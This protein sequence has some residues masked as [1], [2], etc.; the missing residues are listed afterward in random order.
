MLEEVAGP[1]VAVRDLVEGA[2]GC[3]LTFD[4]GDRSIIDW[5]Y[6]LIDEGQDWPGDERDLLYSIFGAERV[7]VM[8]E[9]LHWITCSERAFT[10][11][12]IAKHRKKGQMFFI[13]RVLVSS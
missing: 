4:D 1:F 11:P 7:I 9:I 6:V 3:A 5:D 12:D 8:A 2:H 13:I 10:S